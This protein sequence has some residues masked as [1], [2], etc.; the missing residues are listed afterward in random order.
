MENKYVVCGYTMYRDSGSIAKF[1]NDT[2]KREHLKFV[3]I[4]DGWIVFEKIDNE[5]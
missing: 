2:C 3:S 5:D 4:G 1:I